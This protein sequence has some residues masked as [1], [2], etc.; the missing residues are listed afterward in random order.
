MEHG[1]LRCCHNLLAALRR[2]FALMEE[3]IMFPVLVAH[4]LLL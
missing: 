4:G 3:V 1:Q 2:M